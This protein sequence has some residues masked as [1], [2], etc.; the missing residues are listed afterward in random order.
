ME[1]KEQQRK[2]I[3]VMWGDI[4]KYVRTAYE[5]NEL[6]SHEEINQIFGLK[7]PK[8]SIEEYKKYSFERLNL[9]DKLRKLMLENHKVYLRSYKGEGFVL[10]SPDNQI[11]YGVEHGYQKLQK[12][13]K[14]TYAILD[15]V[16]Q[17]ALSQESKKKASD[18]KAKLSMLY[19]MTKK[20]FK[21]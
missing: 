11:D 4:T 21:S 1:T 3:S 9:I 5:D 14:Q 7:E 18:N 13:I 8:T 16:K 20:Q 2:E 12:V 19:S 17:K 10:L 15:N 6:I